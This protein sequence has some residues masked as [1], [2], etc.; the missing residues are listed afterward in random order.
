MVSPTRSA[1]TAA[2]E[3]LL[4]Y[5][6]ATNPD[7]LKASPEN[8]GVPEETG[9][10]IIVGS[11]RSGASADV[12]WIK[13]K[14]PAGTMSPDLATDLSKVTPR[15]SLDGWTVQLNSSTKEF[16]FSPA[17]SHAPVGPETGFTI[18]LSELPISR[19]VGTA[20]ITVTESSR[21]GS[22][23]FASRSTIFNVGKFPADFYLRN[24][25]ANPLVIDNGG[26][27]TLTWE[28]SANATYELLYGE[29]SLDV[30]NVT[31]RTVTN[32]KTNTTFY[33]RG[34]T[35][36]PSNPVTR[37]LT[38]QV[39]VIKPDLEV[40][41]LIVNGTITAKGDVHIA[42]EKKLTLNNL[43]PAEGVG[44]NV[45]ANLAIAADKA[46]TANHIRATTNTADAVLLQGALTVNGNVLAK[47][48][49]TVT[50]SGKVLRVRELRGPV[51]QGGEASDPPINISN[52]EI[53]VGTIHGTGT[54]PT[55]NIPAHVN[56]ST[57]G[58]TT[59]IAGPLVA[60]GDATISGAFRANGRVLM[61]GTPRLL[62][63]F[64]L[65]SQAD[66]QQRYTAAT[67]GF[68]IGR[69]HA[70]G[71]AEY[72][73]MTISTGGQSITDDARGISYAGKNSF[74]LPVAAGQVFTVR[75]QRLAG[76]S[77]PGWAVAYFFWVPLGSGN[78][79]LSVLESEDTEPLPVDDSGISTD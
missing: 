3:P 29:T 79:T 76:T 21:E 72:V 59:T 19:K 38:A 47:S 27:T 71:G 18:Q 46:L 5:E 41:Q 20:P 6:L 37:I 10:L 4:S 75:G 51:K 63:E 61:V 17:A 33:L 70:G 36:D 77:N 62:K 54:Y 66:Q 45:G 34:T 40:G 2:Q 74:S 39:T 14:V 53:K 32:I 42:K 43:A 52:G 9:E 15:I 48:H 1:D 68:V 50:E 24:F 30:T 22:S 60:S 69:G 65:S 23:A 31:T 28:R 73:R 16:V 49:V 12:Q 57:S 67:S 64:V 78:P 11:R 58:R 35:G 44:I 55:V 13:V 56:L 26:Q 8:I 25:I 7:P